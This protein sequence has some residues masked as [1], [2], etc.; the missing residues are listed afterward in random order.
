MAKKKNKEEALPKQE[1]LG[2]VRTEASSESLESGSGGPRLY[3]IIIVFALFLTAAVIWSVFLIGTL[4]GESGDSP[5]DETEEFTE[6]EV[7][8]RAV[9]GEIFDC[10][11]KPLV[12][13]VYSYGLELD[14]S[15]FPS[16]YAAQNESLSRLLDIVDGFGIRDLMLTS[17]FPFVGTYPELEYD[18]ELLSGSIAKG[19]FDRIRELLGLPEEVGAPEFAAKLAEYYRLTDKDGEPLYG[20]ER[21]T[22]LVRIRYEMEAIR[23]SKAEPYPMLSGIGIKEITA[24]R[25][26]GISFA[27]ITVSYTRQYEYP[28][29]ASHILGRIGK[30]QA[31]N[32]E[33]YTSLGYPV[34][35]VVGID[36]CEKAFENYLRGVDGIMKV[37]EDRN[38]HTVKTEI[39]K[40]PEP[41]LDVILTIDIDLQIA[42]EHALADNIGYVIEKAA[43]SGKQFEG[44]DCDCGALVAERIGTGELLAVASY[45]TFD[46]ST[47]SQD[48]SLL[49]EDARRPLFNRALNGTYACGSTFKIGI[50]V[51]ALTDGTLMA[52]GKPF[53][54]QTKIMTEGKYTYYEDYQPECWI[55]TGSRS[56]HG[57]IDV[58]RAIQVSCNCFFYEVGRLMEIGNINKYC[59]YYGLGQP[60]GIELDESTGVLADPAY[61]SKMGVPWTGGLTI[62][63][64]IGQGYNRF[65][66]IQLANY[67]CTVIDGGKRYSLRIL[68]EVRHFGGELEEATSPEILS[69]FVMTSDTLETIRGAMSKVVDENAAVT[70]FD[71]FGVKVGGKTGS[72]QVTGQSSN[73]VF[74]SFAPLDDPEIAVSCVLERGAHGA[75]AAVG[76]RQ[77]MEYYFGRGE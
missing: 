11:R 24:F 3:R 72:A 43:A 71:G 74:I 18:S 19:R 47:F 46:L 69:S 31:E 33:Y 40:E 1:G 61:T 59:V 13:N 73:A 21:M 41:G 65:T 38:G 64:A 44:E 8:I 28:G 30:I 23:F 12:T 56:K 48:Y 68:K 57:L 20:M 55:Y 37:T 76:V 15:A 14:Y 36:G 17:G 22:D 29:Y 70:A 10:N 27:V 49:I 77:F 26:S 9:R 32:A 63:T 53:T 2:P 51:G 52:D 16:G 75:N 7:A 62:Q 34:T 58:T 50:A 6:R 35:A 45:P 60:T 54:S 42:A 66:P 5:E 67:M 4:F 25:E 39:I